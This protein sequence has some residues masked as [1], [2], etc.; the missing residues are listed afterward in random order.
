MHINSD[1]SISST[2]STNADKINVDYLLEEYDPSSSC[3]KARTGP[4]FIYWTEI[5]LLQ[6]CN[7]SLN[8]HEFWGGILQNLKQ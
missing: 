2:S 7:K 6:Y 8:I 4:G 3:E 1:V 5:I